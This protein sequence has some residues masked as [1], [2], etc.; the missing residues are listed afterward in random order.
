MRNLQAT[1]FRKGDEYGMK[2]YSLFDILGPIMIGPSSSH[3]AGAE[4]LGRAAKQI[5][6]DGIQSV[7]FYLHG[8]FAKTYKGHGTDRALIAGI[9]G[10]ETYD[11]RIKESFEIAQKQGI[12]IEFIEADLGDVHPNTVKIAITKDD[13]TTVSVT[14]S[15]IGGGNIVI[16]NIDG[17]DVEFTGNYP[18][19]LI[20]HIDKRGMISKISFA[21]A[22]NEI[23]IA[24]LK[25]SRVLK[26]D[27]ATTVVETDSNITSTVLEEISTI[28]SVVSVRAVNRI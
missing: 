21:L 14:G 9:L 26:G 25:V 1:Q 28:D 18:V 8:S 23:N 4:R 11:E 27:V 12:K 2:E 22:M 17:D 7:R 13:N 15:S 6:G 24:T 16:L 20:K 3:T 19:I 5:A 10:M